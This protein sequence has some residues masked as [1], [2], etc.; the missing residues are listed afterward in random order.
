MKDDH[1]KSLI[2]LV[3]DQEVKYALKGISDNIAPGIDD[4]GAKF[5]KATWNII[6]KDVLN[7]IREFF[8]KDTMLKVIDSTIVTL[9]PKTNQASM[10]KRL[11]AYF[12]L[13]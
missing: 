3:I 6:N 5:F 11:Q 1:R 12:L 4:F 7:S 2:E 10:V 13:H 9:I 8:E